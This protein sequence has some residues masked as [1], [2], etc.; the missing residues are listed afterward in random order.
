MALHS[1][2]MSAF[3][4]AGLALLLAGCTPQAPRLDAIRPAEGDAAG[5]SK[6]RLEGAGFVG[7]GRLVVYFGMRSARA[8]V[9]EDDRLI[10][11]VAPE[12][13]AEGPTDLRLQFGDG[14]VLAQAQ[15]Y[16]YNAADGGLPVIPFVP[17]QTPVPSAKE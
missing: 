3:R 16:H 8:V 14:T 11:V 9:I 17:G 4:V 10:T 12:A 5:G 6:V 1:A 2:A 13:E 15:G 7:H